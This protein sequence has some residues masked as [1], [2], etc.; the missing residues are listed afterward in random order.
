MRVTVRVRGHA[1]EFFPDQREEYDYEFSEGQT[2]SDM[3]A[4]LGIKSEL[5]MRVVVDG[6]VAPKSHVL[7]DGEVVTLLTPVSG[8]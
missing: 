4:A 2:V 8:G 3:L 7:R 1:R 5:V 6:A